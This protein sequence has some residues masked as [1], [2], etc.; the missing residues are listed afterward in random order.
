MRD[1][2][3]GTTAR[4]TFGSFIWRLIFANSAS[5]AR[6]PSWPNPKARVSAFC[7]IESLKSQ[8]GATPVLLEMYFDR[9]A[10]GNRRG[11]QTDFEN[12]SIRRAGFVTERHRRRVA[13]ERTD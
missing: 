5:A 4:S 1:F 10:L 11:G 6:I 12:V 8:T 3:A 2:P 13:V 7:R 9:L